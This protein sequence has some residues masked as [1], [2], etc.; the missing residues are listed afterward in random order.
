MG[1]RAGADRTD[2]PST[3]LDQAS[4][5]GLQSDHEARYV[6]E[7]DNRNPAD[8]INQRFQKKLGAGLLPGVCTRGTG[9]PLVAEMDKL[10]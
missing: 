10:S 6:M 7:E 3:L 4:S 8:R 5:F 9:S 2:E 1:N